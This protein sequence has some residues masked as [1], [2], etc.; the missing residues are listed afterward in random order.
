MGEVCM[1]KFAEFRA[2][3]ST[4]FADSQG[5]KNIWN[6]YFI[7][8]PL[9]LFFFSFYVRWRPYSQLPTPGKAIGIIAIVAGVMGVREMKVIA[10]ATWIALLIVLL[11]T[12]FRA[13]D[14][15]HYSNE[16]AQRIFFEK[17]RLGFEKVT[18]QASQNFAN[19]TEGL[20]VAIAGIKSTLETANKTLIQTQPRAYFGPVNFKAN[21]NLV[22][23]TSYSFDVHFQNSG[24]DVA[25]KTTIYAN[26][27]TGKYNDLET[28]K[29]ISEKFERDW[30]RNSIT[31]TIEGIRMLGVISPQEPD[32]VSFHS[33]IHSGEDRRR[34]IDD[35]TW[36][37]YTLSRIAYRDATGEW[38]SDSCSFWQIPL[39][40]P[41]IVNHACRVNRDTRHSPKQP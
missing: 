20:T 14:K 41:L 23:N 2:K 29:E 40:S 27:Y 35:K 37:E 39:G 7:G 34:I 12:E 17:E 13:I 15:D 9:W 11:F 28:E 16:E 22:P 36:T 5:I 1:E 25:R 31:P 10:K 8:V 24:N 30:K 26:T 33:Q 18:N 4:I 32:W 3:V 6:S 19:T 21:A 38:Y